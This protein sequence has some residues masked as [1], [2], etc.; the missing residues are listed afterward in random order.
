MLSVLLSTIIICLTYFIC[1]KIQT[2]A[3]IKVHLEHLDFERAKYINANPS[4]DK[5][6]ESPYKLKRVMHK[7]SQQWGY[8]IAYKVD[9]ENYTCPNGYYQI[10]DIEKAKKVLNEMEMVEGYIKTTWDD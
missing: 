4:M 10:L 5:R 7:E 2:N 9:N 6:K 3:Y 1:K 8:T